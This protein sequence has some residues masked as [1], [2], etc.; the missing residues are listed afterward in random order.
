MLKALSIVPCVRVRRRSCEAAPRSVFDAA[1]AIKDSRSTGVRRPFAHPRAVVSRHRQQRSG[2]FFAHPGPRSRPH[3]FGPRANV[4][5]LHA[6]QARHRAAA[7]GG[8]RPVDAG[9]RLAAVCRCTA[10]RLGRCQQ[11]APRRDP[12]ACTSTSHRSAPSALEKGGLF[13]KEASWHPAGVRLQLSAAVPRTASALLAP[14]LDSLCCR[15][16]PHVTKGARARVLDGSRTKHANPTED[17]ELRRDDT[18][19]VR[20]GQRSERPHHRAVINQIGTSST[21]AVIT[22]TQSERSR[23]HVEPGTA[24]GSRAEVCGCPHERDSRNR[25]TV[26]SSKACYTPRSSVARATRSTASANAAWRSV[27]VLVLAHAAM[28]D[29]PCSITRSSSPLTRASSQRMPWTFCTHSK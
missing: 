19:I 23:Y 7:P 10:G 12:R 9:P 11:P 27:H 14:Q 17:R 15:P 29:H 3:W 24:C 25:S 5:R 18:A 1:E 4:A 2:S 20:H 8:R 6:Q 21:P 28:S 13:P 26:R 16:K 22:T